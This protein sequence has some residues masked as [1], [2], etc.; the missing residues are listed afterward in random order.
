MVCLI[1]QDKQIF[2]VPKAEIAISSLILTMFDEDDD[3]CCQEIPLP[4]VESKILAIVL[5]FV[6]H[7]QVES[8]ETIAQV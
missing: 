1:S 2:H 6:K 7:H 5:E 3:E 4:N 8:M